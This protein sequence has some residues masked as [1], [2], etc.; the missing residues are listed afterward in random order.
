VKLDKAM[1][2]SLIAVFIWSMVV[3]G[4]V[5]SIG[6]GVVL[7]SINYIAKPLV[8][9]MGQFS[10]NEKVLN[11]YPGRTYVTGAWTCTDP[12]T[13]SRTQ[14]SA[15]KMGLY[16]GPFY[17]L[18]LFLAVLLPWYQ[19]TISSQRKKA[20]DADWQRKWNEEFGRKN[21]HT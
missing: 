3:G 10:Y 8:C 12:E 20:A 16:T 7:P 15:L 18:L 9:P 1:I 17:G 5:I 13:G 2:R 21:S 4:A 6:I 19:F 14:I 11:P